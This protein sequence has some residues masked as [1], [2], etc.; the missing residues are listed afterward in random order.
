MNNNIDNMVIDIDSW[1]IEGGYCDIFPIK[2]NPNLI[3]KEFYKKYRANIAYNIQKKLAKFDLAPKIYGKVQQLPFHSSIVK[4]ST[5]SR[6]GYITEKAGQ[7]HLHMPE[8]EQL[9]M[10]QELVDDIQ[11]KT[12]LK[13][14]DCHHWNIGTIIR[15][16]KLKLV[17]IDTGKESFN[18]NVNAWGNTEPGPMCCYCDTYN[19]QC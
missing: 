2:N 12:K 8:K 6:F 11:T 16:K 9:D 18:A 4:S 15:D 10:I 3:F 7:D 14:W 17:C 13:F 19:C 5:K 1:T